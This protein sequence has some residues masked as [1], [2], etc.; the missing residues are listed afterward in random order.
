MTILIRKPKRTRYHYPNKDNVFGLEINFRP[1][2]DMKTKLRKARL[3]NQGVSVIV[4]C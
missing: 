3:F 2:D 4:A 1:T